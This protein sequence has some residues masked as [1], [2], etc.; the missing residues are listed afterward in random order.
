MGIAAATAAIVGGIGLTGVAATAATIGLDAAF[1][2][3]LGAL[4]SEI[5]GGDPG[6]GA[7]FG[8]LTGG[9]AGGAGEAFSA[10]TAPASDAAAAASGGAASAAAPIGSAASVPVDFTSAGGSGL[11]TAGGAGADLSGA[12]GS[13]GS[14]AGTGGLA[15][16]G[17]VGADL[18]GAAGAIGGAAPIAVTG[19]GDAASAL[20]TLGAGGG[21]GGGVAAP[22]SPIALSADQQAATISGGATGASATP[23]S[24]ANIAG[25]AG[26]G[27]QSFLDKI[28]SGA[29]NSVTKNPLGTVLAGAGLVKDIAGQKQDPNAKALANQAAALNAQIGQLTSPLTS[30]QLPPGAQSAVNQGVASAKAAIRA[31]YASLGLSGSTM[32]TQDLANID[33]QQQ[34]QVFQLASNLFSQGIQGAQLSEQ[35]YKDLLGANTQ[36]NAAT[37]QAIGNLAAAL[38]GGGNVTLKVA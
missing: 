2:A 11:L 1:G 29:T 3:G 8:G 6:Q 4:G 36:Q 14:V 22:A 20:G 10:A 17:G 25:G 12:A 35:I 9:I 16:A 37:G 33:M 24:S 34:T 7:L 27:P 21:G 31:K 32:E 13:V 28:V 38:N 18:S 5:T 15:T 19:G 23:L 26:A 30:G